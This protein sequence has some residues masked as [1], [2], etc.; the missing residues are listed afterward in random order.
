LFLAVALLSCGP[1]I[2]TPLLFIYMKVKSY[3]LL[4]SKSLAVMSMPTSEFAYDEL[5]ERAI[6]ELEGNTKGK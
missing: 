3:K 4:V 1:V 2:S 5:V 6:E